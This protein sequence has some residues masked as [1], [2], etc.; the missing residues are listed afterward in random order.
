MLWA[1]GI[2]GIWA[3]VVLLAV[4]LAGADDP[5]ILLADDACVPRVTVSWPVRGG[6]PAAHAGDRKYQSPGQKSPLAPNL[7]CYV[8][9]GGVRLDKAAA[10]PDGAV[11]RVGLYKID[12]KKPLFENLGDDAVVTIKV[13]N[14]RMS[15]AAHATPETGL[16]H[17]RYMLDDLA[18][19]GISA[20]GRNQFITVSPKD[21]VLGSVQAE[22]ARAGA[23]DGAGAG[24]GSVTV[25][26]GPSGTSTVTFRF[27]YA[28][29]RHLKDP[30]HRT[31]P[32]GFFEPQHFHCE[33][34]FMP[35]PAPPPKEPD[36]PPKK[37]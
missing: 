3:G 22:S 28:L 11:V 27:P 2:W 31:A 9:L 17:L 37:K 14:L 20:D 5:P 30:S 25:E 18:A 24:H 26:R 1:R 10:H 16:M 29:L 23:L 19:C 34:E 7:E 32:S 36:A 33:I 21:R 8:A 12:A 6:E 13:E 15:R 4:G 35:D